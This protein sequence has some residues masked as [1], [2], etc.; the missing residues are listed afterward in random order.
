MGSE[1]PG[2]AAQNRL[3]A[4]KL[5]YLGQHKQF[6]TYIWDMKTSVSLEY[7]INFLSFKGVKFFFKI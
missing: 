6:T 4:Q 5:A 3:G 1:C 7:F 2:K